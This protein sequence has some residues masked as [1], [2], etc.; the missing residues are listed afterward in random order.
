MMGKGLLESGWLKGEWTEEKQLMARGN[1]SWFPVSE[2]HG[3]EDSPGKEERAAFM[4]VWRKRG[5]DKFKLEWQRRGVYL[6][7]S[8]Y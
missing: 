2:W 7:V 6:V 8:A 3:P 1:C 5:K 4:C